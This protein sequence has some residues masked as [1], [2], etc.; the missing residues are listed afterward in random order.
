MGP[1]KASFAVIGLVAAAL[2]ACAP[3][4]QRIPVR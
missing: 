2:W 4:T 3:T 1:M